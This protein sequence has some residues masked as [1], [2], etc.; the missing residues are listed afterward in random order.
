M[1]GLELDVRID[2]FSPALRQKRA[3]FVT[4]HVSGE[5]HGCIGTLQAE[6]PLIVDVAKNAYAA[7]FRDP[8][9]AAITRSEFQHLDIHISVLNP[10]EPV[11]CTSEDDLLRQLRPG[12]DGLTL[13]ERRQRGTFLPAVWETLPDPR[14]FLRHLKQKAGLPPDYWSDSIRFERYTAESIS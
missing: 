9:F 8:R 4:L 5:L 13:I 7:A 11:Q 3:T 12:V 2:G 6:Q 1:S 10:P 14:E